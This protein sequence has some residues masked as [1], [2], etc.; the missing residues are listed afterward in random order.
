MVILNSIQVARD[1]MDRRSSIY[2]DR[3]RFVLFSELMGWH[4]ASTHMRY[5]ARFRKHRRFIQRVFNQRAV[6]ALRPLQ[7]QETLTLINGLTQTPERFVQH[8]RRY[9]ASSIMK[10]TYG[11]TITSVDDPFVQLAERAG[12]LTVESGSPAAT[13][14]D[15]F[16]FMKHIPTWAPFSTFKRNALLTR[17]AVDKMMSIPFEMVK[18]EMKAGSAIPSFTS[19]LLESCRLPGEEYVTPEDEA[20]IKGAAGTLYA[21]SEDTTVCIMEAFFLA[22]T[23]H[24]EVYAKVQAEIDS[25][26]RGE[27]L[28]DFEDRP[29]LPYLECV[30]QEVYRWCPPVPLG[31]PH[32]LME[33]DVYRGYLV[34]S[35][36]TVIANIYAM[37]RDCPDPESFRPE[38]FMEDPDTL[39]PRTMIFG[40]GRRI[41]PG[42]HYAEAGLWFTLSRI[43][44][45]LD[46][47]QVL[48]ETGNPLTP[49]ADFTTAFVRH[50]K[51]FPC[52]ITPREKSIKLLQA[53]NAMSGL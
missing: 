13:L 30:L 2:S 3:P 21:A 11:H 15:F 40:F 41:C 43:I 25:V 8:F 9:A 34:P 17:E 38:R 12:T 18:N 29:L 1:L 10:I 47:S 14:V 50:P 23:R 27:R 35:G 28:P 36:S 7:E 37:T 39:D 24:P 52:K 32:R 48:D 26:T 51:P 20:D 31:L 44:A 5:G 16:P 33:D 53:A 46:I 4:T 42:R 45:T 22:M 49:E 19:T 6:P